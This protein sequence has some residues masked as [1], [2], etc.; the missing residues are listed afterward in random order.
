MARD[1][2]REAPHTHHTTFC[3]PFSRHLLSTHSLSLSAHSLPL[4]TAAAHDV[5]CRQCLGM[6]VSLCLPSLCRPVSSSLVYRQHWCTCPSFVFF[7]SSLLLSS[8]LLLHHSS[9]HICSLLC[10]SGYSKSV[11]FQH[12]DLPPTVLVQDHAPHSF[13]ADPPCTLGYCKIV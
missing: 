10:S 5:V 13:S 7:L 2:K 9:F 11:C 8:L 6:S 1:G 3:S 4:F 12:H